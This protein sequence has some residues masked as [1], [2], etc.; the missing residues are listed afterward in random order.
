EN[1]RPLFYVAPLAPDEGETVA[2]VFGRG[3]PHQDAPALV[4]DAHGL[5]WLP[6]AAFAAAFAQQASASQQVRL[7]AAQRPISITCITEAVGRPRWRDRPSWF[8]VAAEDR[9]ITAQNQRFM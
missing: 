7:R 4:P 8:L 2:E 6:D 3:A 5:I 9:M 1:V